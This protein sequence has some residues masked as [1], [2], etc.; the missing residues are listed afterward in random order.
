MIVAILSDT[1]GNT[2]AFVKVI[3]VARSYGASK[4]FHIGDLLG[5]IPDLEILDVID[6]LKL[7]ITFTRGN[8]EDAIIKKTINQEKDDILKH[9]LL[10]KQLTNNQKKFLESFKTFVELQTN[11]GIAH[12]SHGGPLSPIEGYV[13]EQNSEQFINFSYSHIFVGNTHRPFQKQIG[14]QKIVNVGSCGLPRDNGSEG[15][16][17]LLDTTHKDV[18]LVRCKIPNLEV[19]WPKHRLV[20]IHETVLQNYYRKWNSNLE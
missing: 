17:A 19:V 12:L 14:R 6:S 20:N 15:S 13:Y 8:H 2:P 9:G 3:N 7:D 10:I 5:Y 1:H 4:F 18:E 16:F 11:S